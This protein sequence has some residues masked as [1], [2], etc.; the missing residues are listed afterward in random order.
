MVQIV[1]A[2]LRPAVG[3]LR[4]RVYGYSLERDTFD[5]YRAAW[6]ADAVYSDEISVC[7]SVRQT[8]GLPLLAIT[9]PPCIAVS[10]IAE[11]LVIVC[12]HGL[13]LMVFRWSDAVLTTVRFSDLYSVAC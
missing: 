6:N 11:L 3:N 5:F 8:R 10:A 1:N 4:L 9:N 12:S 13:L 2:V 7:L